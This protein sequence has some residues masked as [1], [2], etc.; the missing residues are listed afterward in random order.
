MKLSFTTF[1][2]GFIPASLRN[3]GESYRRAKLLVQISFIAVLTCPLIALSYLSY[4]HFVAVS[5]MLIACLF[6]L[7]IPW[8]VKKIESQGLCSTMFCTILYLLLNSL[9][10]TTGGLQS[11]VLP[12]MMTIP[13]LAALTFHRLAMWSWM[14]IILVT[15]IGYFLISSVGFHFINGVPSDKLIRSELVAA[16]ALLVVLTS[17]AFMFEKGREEGYQAL[18][19]INEEAERLN[20]QMRSAQND[21]EEEKN[22]VREAMVTSEMTRSH[23]AKSVEEMLL[24]I[25]QFSRG[26]LR[27]HLPAHTSDEIG[28]LFHSFNDAISKM[29][30]LL[31]RVTTMLETT[32][33]TSGAIENRVHEVGDSLEIQALQTHKM[34]AAMEEITET[35]RNTAEQTSVVAFEAHGAEEDAN[36]G[37]EV[38]EETMRTVQSMV[39]VITRATETVANL[40]KSSES[41]GMITG[42]IDEIAD[43]TN[44]LALNAAIEAARAGE[45]GRGFAV[46]ADEVRK[47]AERTQLATKEI[48]ATVKQIQQQSFEAMLEMNTGQEEAEKGRKQVQEAKRSLQ[49]IIQRTQRVAKIIQEIVRFGEHQSLRVSGLVQSVNNVRTISDRSVE[50]MSYVLEDVRHLVTITQNLDASVRYFKIHNEAKK[51]PQQEKLPSPANLKKNTVISNTFVPFSYHQ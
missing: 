10:F 49:K 34:A 21:L 50:A 14:L 28:R 11:T 16:S 45:Q 4:Q 12:W 42:I 5:C 8:V 19:R 51:I 43:Q 7:C 2:E 36:K 33:A 3:D 18:Q 47:L 6:F 23:L 48:A 1:I 17:V 27:I 13:L 9:L 32:I 26:D 41:I 24:R 30:L 44:L 46:V 25:E 31:T 37:G 15:I 38:V 35:I 40:G 20:K 39:N 29:N 22:K